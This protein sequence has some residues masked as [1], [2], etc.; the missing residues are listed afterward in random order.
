MN[1]QPTTRWQNEELSFKTY[2]HP[3]ANGRKAQFGEQEC[4]LTFPLDDKRTLT[5]RIGKLGFEALTEN[6]MKML[7]DAP[8]CDDDAPQAPKIFADL[9]AKLTAAE[10]TV[11]Q[12]R[13]RLDTAREALEYIADEGK[14]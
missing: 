14:G 7:A 8:S 5:L 11:A 3:E 9:Q 4:T 10:G 2:D 12:L 1:E 6:L 13:T